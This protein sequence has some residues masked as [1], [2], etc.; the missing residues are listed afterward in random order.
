[1]CVGKGE[2]MVRQ[3]LPHH[4]HRNLPIPRGLSPA[5]GRGWDPTSTLGDGDALWKDRADQLA[6][7]QL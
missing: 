7:A 2:G 1:M 5:G 4:R 6:Q 3:L